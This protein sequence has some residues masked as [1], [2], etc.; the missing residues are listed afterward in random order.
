MTPLARL[1]ASLLV[2][3]VLAW[4]AFEA[5]VR[6][7]TDLES[8]VLRWGIAFVGARVAFGVIGRILE[9]YRVDPSE[10]A[11]PEGTD[12][13]ADAQTGHDGHRR[14]DDGPMRATR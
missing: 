10:E 6:G 3:V 8:A 1:A 2:S 9:A 4:P 14:V 7:A 13:D 11:G 12:G 5:C